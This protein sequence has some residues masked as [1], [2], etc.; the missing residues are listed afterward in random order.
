MG[1]GPLTKGSDRFSHH[2]GQRHEPFQDPHDSEVIRFPVILEGVEQGVEEGGS[3]LGSG[4][5][6]GCFSQSGK[7]EV[8]GIPTVELDDDAP[9]SLNPMD[10]ESLIGEVG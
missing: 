8:R 3:D 2:P 6:I 9:K 5:A 10:H 4:K 7:V 1:F